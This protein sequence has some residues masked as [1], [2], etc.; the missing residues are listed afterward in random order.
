MAALKTVGKTGSM[1]LL[2][3][4][5]EHLLDKYSD[6]LTKTSSGSVSL[7]QEQIVRII[8]DT[9]DDLI[10]KKFGIHSQPHFTSRK[11]Y[12]HSSSLALIVKE[13]DIYS[14]LKEVRYNYCVRHTSSYIPNSFTCVNPRPVQ[15]CVYIR[16][17]GRE[18]FSHN[19]VDARGQQ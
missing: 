1:K 3:V 9:I 2:E 8:Q 10:L 17:A 6:L 7:S 4:L 13:K 12:T 14:Y 15:I 5:T 18:E 16:Y 19:G 11:L